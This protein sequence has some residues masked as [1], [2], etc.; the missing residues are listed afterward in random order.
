MSLVYKMS[1]MI[2][3][4]NVGFVYSFSPIFGYALGMR[5]WKRAREAMRNGLIWQMSIGLV[6]WF[7]MNMSCEA[8]DLAF[9]EGYDPM[10]DLGAF[11]MRCWHCM[12]PF[13]PAFLMM[14]EISKMEYKPFK[15]LVVQGSRIVFVV[16]F[17]LIF[18]YKI[19]AVEGLYYAFIAG[20]F[21]ASVVG[22]IVFIERYITY[23]KLERG[24]ITPE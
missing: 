23:G 16:V 1:P 4:S 15:A 17:E 22:L 21:C 5:D 20:D 10:A 12:L 24:E 9:M 8:F 11:G 6:F 18:G 2:G 19:P 14:K 7:V 13:L 3:I